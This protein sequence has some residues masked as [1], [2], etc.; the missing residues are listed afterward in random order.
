MTEIDLDFNE[1]WPLI[2]LQS[3]SIFIDISKIVCIKIRKIMFIEH[4]K[5]IWKD[6]NMVIEQAHNLSSLSIDDNFSIKYKNRTIKSISSILPRRLKHLEMP[7]NDL[8][9]IKRILERCEN[10]AIIIFENA[11]QKFLDKTIKWFDKNI[12]NTTC[13]KNDIRVYIWLGKKT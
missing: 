7:I 6:I 3:L 1:D 2:S 10:L 12:I 5:N 13:K 8:R 11:N 4:D 9:Q